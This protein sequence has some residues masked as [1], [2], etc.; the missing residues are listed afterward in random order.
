M[1]GNIYFK[2]MYKLQKNYCFIDGHCYD[3]K[4]KKDEYMCIAELSQTDWTGM[5][6]I[7]FYYITF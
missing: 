1:E 2:I 3:N 4:E 7:T 6:Y 5:H